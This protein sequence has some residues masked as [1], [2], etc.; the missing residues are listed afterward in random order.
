MAMQRNIV[1][2]ERFDTENSSSLGLSLIGGAK[3]LGRIIREPTVNRPGLALEGFKRYFAG[4]R[5][6]VMGNAECHY[7]KSLTPQERAERYEDLFRHKIPCFVFCRNLEP[8][9]QF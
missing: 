2:V 8:E 1:T 9:K 4:K 6:Q 5:I 3:G 7:L